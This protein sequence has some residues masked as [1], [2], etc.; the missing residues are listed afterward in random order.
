VKKIIL[1]GAVGAIAAIVMACGGGTS[2]SDK[3]STAA[4]GAA[5]TTAATAAATTAASTPAASGTSESTPTPAELSTYIAQLKDIMNQI[6][7][8][9]DAGDVQ[10]ARDTEATMDAAMEAVVKATRAVDSTLADSLEKLE[11]DIEDQA[12]ASTTDLSVMSKDAK[13]VLP[14]LDQIATALNLPPASGTA[15][16][17]AAPTTAELSAY[18]TQLRQIMTDLVAKAQSGDVQ[19]TRDT[20]A[21]MDTAMEA[22]IKATR[23]VDP[24]VA[25]EL[26]KLELDIE[27]QAD[28]STTDLSVI[29]KDAQAVPAVLDKVVTALNLTP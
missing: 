20:E 17:G 14:L 7:A 5:P 15:E 19:A 16:S 12:D 23:A 3:T 11:L 26:E 13:D 18:V 29:E 21:T 9:A 2:S 1:L 8:K 6:V 22:V 24:A 28:A 4:A 25:D 27:D 10:G